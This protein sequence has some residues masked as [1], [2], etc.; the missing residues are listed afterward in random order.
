MTELSFNIYELITWFWAESEER[1]VTPT[2]A[3][4]YSFLL[5]RANARHWQMPLRI[6]TVVIT[7]HINTTRQNIVKART[8]L[9]ALGFIDY[10]SGTNEHDATQYTILNNARQLSAQLTPK[11]SAELSPQLSH[12]NMKDKYNNININAHERNF[13]PARAESSSHLSFA[14]RSRDKPEANL[15]PLSE[16]KQILL[17]DETWQTSVIQALPSCHIQT[18]ND[19]ITHI[20]QFFRVL[21]AK[22]DK[23]RDVND[24]KSYFFNWINKNIKNS[25]D[26]KAT[27]IS[28]QRRGTTFCTTAEKAFE[29]KF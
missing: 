4:L 26:G 16:L 13:V 23:E 14:E 27:I 10:T 9:K 12:Y 17:A 2:E 3:A 21:E 22:G 1:S 18:T 28:S 6:P 29:G 8:S 15:K 11:L 24:C 7:T 19:L 25:N 5:A 20:T